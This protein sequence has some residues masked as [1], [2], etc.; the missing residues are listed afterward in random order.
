MPPAGRPDGLRPVLPAA[1]RLALPDGL[2][3]SPAAERCAARRPAPSDA[4]RPADR[5]ALPVRDRDRRRVPSSSYGATPGAGSVRP[6]RA[7]WR[8]NSWESRRLRPFVFRH[9]LACSLLGRFAFHDDS[10]PSASPSISTSSSISAASSATASTSAPSRPL[11]GTSV[12]TAENPVSSENTWI[13]GFRFRLRSRR[14]FGHRVSLPPVS[15][16][17]ARASLPAPQ[18]LREPPPARALPPSL[19]RPFRFRFHHRFGEAGRRA[20]GF[21]LFQCPAALF[22][23][24]LRTSVLPPIPLRRDALLGQRF[25]RQ[26]EE[27]VLLRV[28]NDARLL[29]RFLHRSRLGNADHRR[30]MMP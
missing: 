29:R 12:S 30:C 16:P 21:K 9:R 25:A 8:S 17:P 18:L 28:E 14:L 4:L 19:G 27:I 23:Q 3:E 13:G 5:A 11:S 20:L 24:R 2:R 1:L 22:G 26:H 7:A 6:A 15:L 10:T